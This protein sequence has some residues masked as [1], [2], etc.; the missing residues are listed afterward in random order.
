MLQTEEVFDKVRA[1]LVDSLGVDESEVTP[2]ASLVVD[3][4]AE[5]IDFLDIVFKI[6]QAFQFKVVQGELYPQ[7]ILGNAALVQNGRLNAEGVAQLQA[8]LPY[9]DLDAFAA[10]PVVKDF[11]EQLTVAD[12]C[13]FVESKSA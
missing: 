13:R 1:I 11:R 3:L 6:E 8:K 5:S 10:N 9:I 2:E 12:M 4:G 7:D